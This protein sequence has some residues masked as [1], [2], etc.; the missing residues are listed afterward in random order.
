M[1]QN[2]KN[3]NDGAKRV[4]EQLAAEKKKTVIAVCLITVMVLMW[5]RVFGKKTPQTAGAAVTA[6]EAITEQSNSELKVSFVEPPKVKGRNDVLSRDFF[7][8][9]NWQ[10]FTR[11]RE[12]E[13]LAGIEEVSVFSKDG[14]EEVVKRIADKLKLEAIVSGKNPQAFIDG[15]LLSAGGKLFVEDGTKKY[16]C[17]VVGIEENTVLIRCGEAEIKLR[18]TKAIE[19]TD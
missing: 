5:V 9:D 13:N 2:L 16:E 15:K 8:I 12:G 11:G 10:E 19:V 18:L 1:R 17:E 14:S 3:N 4:F 7:A 6:Q